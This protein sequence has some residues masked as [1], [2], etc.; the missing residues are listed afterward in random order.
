M[1]HHW[2]VAFDI[3]DADLEQRPIRCWANEHRQV[4]FQS[5]RSR[6]V[7]NCMPYV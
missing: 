3:E 4:V 1:D 2:V 5:Y 7:A 6:R